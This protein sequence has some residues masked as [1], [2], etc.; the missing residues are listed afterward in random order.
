MEPG[1]STLHTSQLL[2]RGTL[3]A[4]ALLSLLLFIFDVVVHSI[5]FG[6]K[7]WMALAVVVYICIGNYILKNKSST[8]ANWMLIIFYEILAF[9]TLFT[10]GLNAPVGILTVSFAIILPSILMGAKSIFPVVTITVSSL[11]LVQFF[12]DQKIIT[13]DLDALSQPSTFWDVLTYSIILSIFALVSWIAGNQREKALS[14][15]L[16]AE[17][18]LQGQRDALRIELEKE[19]AALRRTQLKQI[20][21]LH[22]FAL[23]GQSAAATLHDLSSHLSVLNLDID[24]LQQQHANSEAIVNAKESIQHINT[25]VRQARQQLNSYDQRETFDAVAIVNQC[26]QDMHEKFLHQHIEVN[27]SLGNRSLFLTGS[28]VALMQI[29]TVLLN[30][31]IDACCCVKNPHIT[32]SLKTTPKELTISVMDNGTGLDPSLQASLF[33][34]VTSKKSSGMGVGLYI[35]HHLTK[36]QFDGNINIAPSKRGAHF[37]VT[38]PKTCSA[39]RLAS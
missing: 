9:C 32:I 20:R 15:A 22:R 13:P 17:Q 1:Y 31:A 28:S 7:S 38:I 10:W 34:P 39:S 21:E 30:N 19:S 12:H 24:D 25:M 36:N 5:W 2:F 29:L 6:S 4:T 26:L 35:A 23:L 8:V 16:R 27:K 33:K 37:I 11:M 14:R 3:I 18:E